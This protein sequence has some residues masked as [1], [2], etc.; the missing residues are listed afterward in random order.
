[1]VAAVGGSVVHVHRE[2]S[3]SLE[4]VGLFRIIS[5]LKYWEVDIENNM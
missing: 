5:I 4:L 1:M 2:N 3:K